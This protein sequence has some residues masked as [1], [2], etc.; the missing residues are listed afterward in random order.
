MIIVNFNYF[1]NFLR[2]LE[3][4]IFVVVSTR[5]TQRRHENSDEK[6]LID[7]LQWKIYMNSFETTFLAS[8]PWKGWRCAIDE[9][10]WIPELNLVYSKILLFIWLSLRMETMLDRKLDIYFFRIS[11]RKFS[12]E[13]KKQRGREKILIRFRHEHLIRQIFTENSTVCCLEFAMLQRL[14]PS[15]PPPIDYNLEERGIN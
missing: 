5:V 14:P 11:K 8:L 15:P 7:S 4:S 12:K 2:K 1:P 9:R 3:T 6:D 10:I 13:S